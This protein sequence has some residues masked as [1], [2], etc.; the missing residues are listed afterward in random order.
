MPTI[1]TKIE[2]QK[3]NKRRYSLYSENKFIIGVSEDSL[4][5]FNI[6][7]GKSLS[8]EDLI[9]IEQKEKYVAIR[10]QAWRFLARRMHSQKELEIKLIN[11]GHNKDKIEIIIGELRDKKY[12]NDDIFARQVI[13][14][15]IELKKTGPILIKNKL[16]K[17][18]VEMSLVSSLL[19]ERYPEESQLDNCE[20]HAKKKLKLLIYKD[21]NSIKNRLGTFLAQKG[22][23][24]DMISR[25][26]SELNL[27]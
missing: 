16:L 17:K 8:E 9:L 20:Y 21:E 13:S 27:E 14:D 7:T 18:G 12:L 2:R 25:V 10:E 23:T 22:F 24:W 15:E 5:E 3:K 1:I 26:I 11:K 6:A 19:D 4:L